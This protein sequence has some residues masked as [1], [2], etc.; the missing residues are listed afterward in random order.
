[1]SYV[2]Y[3]WKKGDKITAERLNN[4]EEGISS[5]GN[6]NSNITEDELI[7]TGVLLVDD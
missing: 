6:N 4:I 7:F 2:P 1:M 3:E 5:S